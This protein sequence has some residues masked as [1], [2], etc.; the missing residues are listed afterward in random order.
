MQIFLQYCYSAILCLE[1]H[2]SK[3]CKKIITFY[4]T[5]S[6]LSLISRLC[7]SIVEPKN[8]ITAKHLSSLSLHHRTQHLQPRTISR[9]PQQPPVTQ[10]HR[11]Q[12]TNSRSMTHDPTRQ[13]QHGDPRPTFAIHD[14]QSTTRAMRVRARQGANEVLGFIEAEL[15]NLWFFVCGFCWLSSSCCLCVLLID[16]EG[17]ELKMRERREMVEKYY[18]IM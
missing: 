5:L 10:H 17:R 3:Y 15:W 18:F 4:L 16:T 6:P 12:P 13:N 2:C 8:H 1:L 9:H 14:P 11:A 7:L